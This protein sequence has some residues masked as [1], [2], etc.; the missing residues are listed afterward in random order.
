M[1]SIWH[2]GEWSFPDLEL[3]FKAVE[4]Q[5]S[6]ALD[7]ADY[8]EVKRRVAEG[9]LAAAEATEQPVDCCLDI[10]G[11]LERLGWS[12]LYGKSNVLASFSTYCLD[13]GRKDVGLRILVP[14]IAELEQDYAHPEE[15]GF[16]TWLDALRKLRA[17][18]QA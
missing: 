1:Q 11:R 14:L 18:L 13:H 7:D 3:G 10:L 6:D 15:A 4:R 16:V 12:S 17:E 2:L 5:F 9:T 8:L